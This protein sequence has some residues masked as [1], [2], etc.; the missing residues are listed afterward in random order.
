MN[1]LL[2]LLVIAGLAACAV[3][4]V[5]L[6]FVRHDA[7]LM[8]PVTLLL[9]MLGVWVYL[10]PTG[11]A[12]YRDCKSTIWIAS[13]NVFLGWTILGWAV[14]MG[15]AASGKIREPVHPIGAPPVQP[16]PGH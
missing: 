8:G 1:N 16:V 7:G 14:A 9:F 12:I 4:I 6:G 5:A 10:L 15:W 13:V 3:V 11:L 2:R